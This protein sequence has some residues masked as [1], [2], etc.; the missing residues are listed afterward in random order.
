MKNY[1]TKDERNEAIQALKDGYENNF[2]WNVDR[3]GHQREFRILQ[4]RGSIVDAEDYLVVT[5]TYP[6]H[7]LTS[8]SPTFGSKT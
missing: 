8:T 2:I 4:K 7:P 5:D 1:L 6:E 3:S